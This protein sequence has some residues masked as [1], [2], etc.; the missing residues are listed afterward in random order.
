MGDLGEGDEV[1]PSQ[2]ATRFHPHS[3]LHAKNIIHRDLKSNSIYLFLSKGWG[4]VRT[5]MS[6]V[7]GLLRMNGG[8][9]CHMALAKWQSCDW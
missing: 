8:G 3:Y 9:T 1:A 4:G 7:G 6:L 2:F 5:L